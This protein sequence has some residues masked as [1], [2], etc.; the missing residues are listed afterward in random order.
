MTTYEAH[1]DD[2]LA[3]LLKLGNHAAFTEIYKRYGNVLY[4]HARHMLHQDDKARDVIQEVFTALWN[5]VTS[6]KLNVSLNAYLYRSVRNTIL[7]AIRHDK[8]A[9]KYLAEL[10]HFYEEG[11]YALDNEL[12]FKELR[13]LIDREIEEL[14]AEIKKVFVLSR[15]AHLS[16]SQIAGLLGKSENTVKSQIG[17]AIQ[18]LRLKL[19]IPASVIFILLNSRIK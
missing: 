7:N 2:E 15:K 5:N 12:H 14:P 17:R 6:L 19:N 3:A 10:G 1:T 4:L 9:G 8:V 18:I 13:R 16:N 11:D